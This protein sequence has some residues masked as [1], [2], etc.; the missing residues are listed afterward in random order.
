MVEQGTLL[1]R[2]RLDAGLATGGMGTVFVATDERLNRKIAIKLLKE[3]LVGDPRFVERFKRE[4]RAVASLSHRNIA[5]VFDYGVDGNQH[6]I[7]MELVEG[8]DLA[9]VIRADGAL[10]AERATRIA[11]QICSA[12]A[13]AHA[14]G[15]V[16]RDI[17]PA[18]VI[19]GPDDIVKVTDFGIAR[20]VGD[21][22]LTATG[23]MLGTATYLSPEQAMGHNV[24]A[25]SDIYSTGIVLYE[26]LTGSSPFVGESPVAIAMKHV[27]EEIPRPGELAQNVPRALDDV[28]KKATQKN[29]QHRYADGAAMEGALRDTTTTTD[30][31]VTTA[32]LDSA[33]QSIW[34]IPGRRWD[35]RKVGRAV[36][37]ALIALFLIA[38]GALAWRLATDETTPGSDARR[39]S[40]TAQQQPAEGDTTDGETTTSPE[41]TPSE[42][43]TGFVIPQ[44]IIGADAG[45]VIEQL[46]D[47]GF[48]VDADE[49]ESDAP[50]NTI[51]AVDPLPGAAVFPGD[52]I[53][54]DVSTGPED[55]S[56]EPPGQDEEEDGD[57]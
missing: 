14:A 53:T 13:H 33:D 56:E 32:R 42:S 9:H 15:V 52:T 1:N 12:L 48:I 43:P 44:D 39:G 3:D 16:H 20:A 8:T 4:A 5:N 55:G 7:V 49:V 57:D 31:Y 27:S 36:L 10:P 22:T 23:S 47:A 51:V 25:A 54:L 24:T 41:P 45:T 38:A 17:K 30:P 11:T 2:Y 6:F 28:V 19:V 46:E 35:P 18:N 50:E 40:G 29:P 21:A 34:P 37:L 26:M